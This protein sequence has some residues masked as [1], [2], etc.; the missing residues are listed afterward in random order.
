M[1]KINPD[2]IR[3]RKKCPFVKEELTNLLDGSVEDTAKRREIEEFFLKSNVRFYTACQRN[4]LCHILAEN[5]FQ[6]MVFL[7]GPEAVGKIQ[8]SIR[9]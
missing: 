4:V 6:V 9:Y 7:K 2:L 5:I 3:E 1:G 8:L